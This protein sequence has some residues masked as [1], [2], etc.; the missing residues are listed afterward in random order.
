VFEVGH[1]VASQA[2][3][4]GVCE[5]Q[6]PPPTTTTDIRAASPARVP[7]QSTQPKHSAKLRAVTQA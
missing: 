6:H 3:F 2:G 7:S 4:H 5:A 1:R